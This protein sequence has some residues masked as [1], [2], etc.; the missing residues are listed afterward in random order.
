MDDVKKQLKKLPAIRYRLVLT[1]FEKHLE[2]EFTSNLIS[3]SMRMIRVNIAITLSLYVVFG[4]IDLIL[5]LSHKHLSWILCP[6]I[7]SLYIITYSKIFK[8][9]FYPT[10]IFYLMTAVMGI[11]MGMFVTRNISSLFFSGLVTFI[12]M[13]YACLRI[14]F[15]YASVMGITVLI[16]YEILSVSLNNAYSLINWTDIFISN[17][18]V[19]LFVTC[20]GM[21]A[22][23]F[24]EYY[25]RHLFL[26]RK[27]IQYEEELK[28]G[29]TEEELTRIKEERDLIKKID[30]LKNDFIAN[31]THEIR[32]PLTLIIGPLEAILAKHFGDTIQYDDPKV[33][34][35]YFN[36]IRLLKLINNIL[37]F[38]RIDAGKIRVTKKNVNIATLLD[39]YVETIKSNVENRGLEISFVNRAGPG[40]TAG[41]DVD[42]L[43]KAIFNLISG[44]RVSAYPTTSAGRYS[45]GFINWTTSRPEN[46]KAAASAWP[47]PRSSLDLSAPPSRS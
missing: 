4:I 19:L 20:L 8:K 35:M 43:E 32:T 13:L 10:L 15:I 30:T 36:G 9:I 25:I 42:I 24:M 40:F 12:I 33:K 3:D 5:N 46:T 41:T 31:V 34:M 11:F 2:A 7:L 26:L 39:F 18:I 22:S 27:R 38:S 37:D 28:K 6:I 23:F 16:A 14:R 44:T 17:S 45:K 47:S 1:G 29:K 21:I